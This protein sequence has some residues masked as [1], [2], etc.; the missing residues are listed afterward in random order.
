MLFS[1]L[2]SEPPVDESLAVREQVNP[3]VKFMVVIHPGSN[4]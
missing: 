4:V 1:K 3:T 2:L